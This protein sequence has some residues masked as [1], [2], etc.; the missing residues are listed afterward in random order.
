VEPAEARARA[1]SSTGGAEVLEGRERWRGEESGEEVA[2]SSSPFSSSLSS[3][4][5]SRS[6]ALGLGPRPRV[7][8]RKKEGGGG[9]QRGDTMSGNS[10]QAEM[11]Y[12]KTE[13]HQRGKKG[14][15]TRSAE[16]ESRADGNTEDASFTDGTQLPII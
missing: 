5:L 8:S 10:D 1:V 2:I 7:S 15:S 6:M 16:F 9:H 12:M 11:N 3:Y 4:P 13:T 14:R